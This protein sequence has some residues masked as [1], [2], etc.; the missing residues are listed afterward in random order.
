MIIKRL[1]FKI[2]KQL[3]AL[4]YIAHEDVNIKKGST[5]YIHLVSLRYRRADYKHIKITE[6]IIKLDSFLLHK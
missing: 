2:T 4:Y 3:E 6:V 1:I 5:T